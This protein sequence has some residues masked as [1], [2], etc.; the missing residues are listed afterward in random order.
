MMELTEADPEVTVST[1]APVEP[2]K[3]ALITVNAVALTDDALVTV[4]LALVVPAFTVT[5]AGTVAALVLLLA[6][7]IVALLDGTLV[8]VT[9]AVLVVPPP[10]IDDGL[11][12]TLATCGPELITA[13][14]STFNSA[15]LVHG[16]PLTSVRARNRT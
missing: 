14:P 5:V 4:K 10:V 15:I 12:V 11:S 7:V 3:L 2:L 16:P 8:S 6:S 9:V 13:E 1:A